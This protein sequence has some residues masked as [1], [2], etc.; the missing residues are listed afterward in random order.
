MQKV[1]VL[2]EI[3]KLY[4]PLSLKEKKE[5]RKKFLEETELS[6]ASFYVC[7]RADTFRPLERNLFIEMIQEYGKSEDNSN[8]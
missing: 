3:Q 2:N 1:C 6:L 8:A 7:L 5:F 4:E